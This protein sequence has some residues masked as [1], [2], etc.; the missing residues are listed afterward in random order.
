MQISKLVQEL[1]PDVQIKAVR[2]REVE[3]LG[4]ISSQKTDIASFAEEKKFMKNIPKNVKLL[5]VNQDLECI[6]SNLPDLGYVI[7]ENPRE[8]FWNLHNSLYENPIY[9]RK[10]RKT[11]IS[12]TAKI[13]PLAQIAPYNVVIGNGV[14]IEAFATIYENT[15][16]EENCTVRSGCRIGSIGFMENKKGKYIETIKHYGGVILH[17]NV[18]LQCNTCVDKAIFP[19][20]N[21]EI[22]EFTKIDN[23]VHIAHSVKIGKACLIAANTTIAGVCNIGDEVWIGLGSTV[24]NRVSIGDYA[25]INMGSVVVENIKEGMSVSGNYAIN[26]TEFLYYQM[27]LKK[28]SGGGL[29]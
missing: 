13:S 26:H 1:Y 20:E 3:T 8:A 7:V 21:T 15:I 17:K 5:L 27:K 22:G 9:I 19:W 10:K 4:F 14:S 16:I 11:Q 18:E 23:L 12:K 24:K 29:Q 2:E 6:S 25:R 28:F